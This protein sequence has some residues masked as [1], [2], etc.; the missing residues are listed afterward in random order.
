MSY[1]Y[2]IWEKSL[3]LGEL[4]DIL[5]VSDWQVEGD[6][7]VLQNKNNNDHVICSLKGVLFYDEVS[8]AC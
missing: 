2:Q 4:G 8:A 3:F 6:F 1:N 5:F 7:A